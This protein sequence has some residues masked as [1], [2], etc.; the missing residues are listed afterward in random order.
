MSNIP[1]KHVEREEKI[2]DE[3]QVRFIKYNVFDFFEGRGEALQGIGKFKGFTPE[4]DFDPKTEEVRNIKMTINLVWEDETGK[5]GE[6]ETINYH[7]SY[8][9]VQ[10]SP[11]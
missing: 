8:D 10:L 6:I 4:A 1:P 7:E 5:M 9:I 3:Q 11:A 2:T